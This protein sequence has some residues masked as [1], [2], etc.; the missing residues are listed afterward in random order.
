MIDPC[1]SRS[2]DP[3]LVA[4]FF[5]SAAEHETYPSLLH[6]LGGAVGFGERPCVQLGAKTR[7]GKQQQQPLRP[8][9]ARFSD[10]SAPAFIIQHVMSMMGGRIVDEEW[11]RRQ[12]NC[13]CPRLLVWSGGRF[14]APSSVRPTMI[15]LSVRPMPL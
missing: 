9:A 10:P 14:C 15:R 1:D 7:K 8:P 11:L 4:G 5:Q 3:P 12:I 13:A 6:G 2:T